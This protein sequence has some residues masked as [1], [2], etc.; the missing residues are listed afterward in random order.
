M[1]AY[2]NINFT[3]NFIECGIVDEKFHQRTMSRTHLKF[4]PWA[5]VIAFFFGCGFRFR[6]LLLDFCFYAVALFVSFRLRLLWN[7]RRN[8]Y[9]WVYNVLCLCVVDLIEKIIIQFFGFEIEYFALFWSKWWGNC[10]QI[11]KR[12]NE[13]IIII[14]NNKIVQKSQWIGN[15]FHW[16]GL[17]IRNNSSDWIGAKRKK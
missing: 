9:E 14:Y 13:R 4:K 11:T 17:C 5:R 10:V 7:F 8:S 1:V 16:I 2:A 12:F 3:L 6:L 15:W